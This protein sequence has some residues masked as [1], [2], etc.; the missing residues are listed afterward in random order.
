MSYRVM[1]LTYSYILLPLNLFVN[2]KAFIHL[3]NIKLVFL[4]FLSSF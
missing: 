4:Q 2:D 1:L 3:C